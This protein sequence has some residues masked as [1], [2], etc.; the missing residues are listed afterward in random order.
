MSRRDVARGRGGTR[1]GDGATDTA[2]GHGDTLGIGVPV[3]GGR[4]AGIAKPTVAGSW[5][6][7][8]PFSWRRLPW[9]R[10][11]QRGRAA[12]HL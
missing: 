10:A 4:S 12:R 6:E 3:S 1:P 8:Q 11:F 5:P 7:T 9:R 2:G